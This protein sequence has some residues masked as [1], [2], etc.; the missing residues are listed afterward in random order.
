MADFPPVYTFGL[1]IWTQ[2]FCQKFLVNKSQGVFL[3]LNKNG[4]SDVCDNV[5]WVTL[6]RWQIL[7]VGDRFKMLVTIRYVGDF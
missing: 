3:M 5:M 6:W 7:D 2:I 1:K 4:Y